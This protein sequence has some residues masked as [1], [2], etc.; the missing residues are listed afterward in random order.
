MRRRPAHLA[1]FVLIA[2]AI[3]LAIA[4]PASAKVPPLSIELSSRTP[5]AGE[6]F[7]ITVRFWDDEART[8]PARWPDTRRFEDFLWL[9]PPDADDAALSVALLR[10]RRGVFGASVA[11]PTPG[12][13]SICFWS[14]APC[15]ESGGGP[16][17]AIPADAEILVLPVSEPE[18]TGDGAEPSEASPSGSTGSGRDDG[19][20]APVATA[21]V[22]TAVVAGAVGAVGARRS[23]R[24]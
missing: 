20:S 12:R 14:A 24:R 7:E 2:S 23:R 13:W 5:R 1:G 8:V 3:A 15:G 4:R 18:S 19:S 17:Y 11:L 21:A 10:S 16:A 6:A 9:V 22:L